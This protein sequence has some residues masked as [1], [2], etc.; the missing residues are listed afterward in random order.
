MPE[1]LGA[2]SAG[3]DD[4]GLGQVA[5]RQRRTE[6]GV[7]V[8]AQLV[9]DGVRLQVRGLHVPAHGAYTGSSGKHRRHWEHTLNKNINAPY[10]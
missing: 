6:D 3:E 4:Q 1:R 8:Q 5:G 2:A 10:N 9:Q 7:H